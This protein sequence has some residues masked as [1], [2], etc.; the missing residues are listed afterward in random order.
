MSSQ[1]RFELLLDEDRNRG[2]YQ[3]PINDLELMLQMYE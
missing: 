1:E 2:Q 3:G